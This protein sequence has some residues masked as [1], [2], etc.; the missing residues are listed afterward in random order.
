MTGCF[1]EFAPLWLACQ[2]RTQLQKLVPA[3]ERSTLRSEFCCDGT[4]YNK[5]VYGSGDTTESLI[6]I[7]L[8]PLDISP[9]ERSWFRMPCPNFTGLCSIYAS[10]RPWICV[11]GAA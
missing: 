4:L 8:T 11:T 10:P 5:A 1:D 2:L 9:D 6:A 3:L 7:G